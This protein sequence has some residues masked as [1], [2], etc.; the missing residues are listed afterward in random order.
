VS[1]PTARSSR[2]RLD[3]LVL[4]SA[5]I[6]DLARW[7][8]ARVQALGGLPRVSVTLYD[9]EAGTGAFVA[10]AGASDPGFEPGV[11]FPLSAVGDLEGLARGEV[12]V[13]PA[14]GLALEPGGALAAAAIERVV[15]VP[16]RAESELI[17]GL[18]FSIDAGGFPGEDGIDM[19]QEVASQ[20]AVAVKQA[21]LRDQV[22][23]HADTL[24]RQVRERTAD[25]QSVNAE[26]EA[27]AYSVSHDLRAPLRAM[28]GIS[29]A[30][31]DDYGDRLDATG[32]D[33]AARIVRAAERMD[34]LIQDLLTYSR[35]SRARI[36]PTRLSL[37]AVVDGALQQLDEALAQARARVTVD[38][39]L[40]DVIGEPQVLVQVVANLVSNAAKFV[41]PGTRPS[42]RIRGEAGAGLAR[43]WVEDNG[44][45]VAPEHQERIFRGFERLHGRDTYP[46]TGIGLAI[47]R[48]GVERL[49]G[50]AGIE[51]VPGEGSRFWIELPSQEARHAGDV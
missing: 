29:Q 50:R 47:V 4:Q 35:V 51:S 6:E 11:T 19:T 48:K 7:A 24:E 1:G 34:G 22:R 27:F 25:L 15:I 38:A 9:V 49:G 46:G 10:V 31:L 14:S 26:M 5:P 41:P 16:V 3:H 45:G 44:I 40:P 23:R 17:G 30:L 28:Q 21:R 8:A 2:S 33:F 18:N 32:R 12:Q 36:V 37:D 20:I 42:I 43:L 39:P 13:L